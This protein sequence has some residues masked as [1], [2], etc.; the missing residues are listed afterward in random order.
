[1]EKKSSVIQKLLWAL[2]VICIPSCTQDTPIPNASPKSTHRTSVVAVDANTWVE[3]DR[4][5]IGS[6]TDGQCYEVWDVYYNLYTGEIVDEVYIDTYCDTVLDNGGYGG[7]GS[8]GGGGGGGDGSCRGCPNDDDL[9]DPFSDFEPTFIFPFAGN[10]PIQEYPNRCAGVQGLWNLSLNNN[11][12]ET[13]GVITADGKF[14]T[15]AVVGATGGSWGGL[16]YQPDVSASVYYSWPD[17]LGP[18]TQN[19]AGMRHV[20]NYYLI[21]I[22]ATVH[23]HS[24]CLVD[25]TDGITNITQISGGDLSIAKAYR[26][27]Q[28]YIVGCDAIGTYAYNSTVPILVERGRLENTC[29]NLN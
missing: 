27:I 15:V 5:A 11:N 8:G 9:A 26:T 24:P 23:T 7:G 12:Q 1:M 14:L 4:R 28:H 21:P 29:V 2:F 17:N 10:K 18:P 19:Y 3:R 13:V 25:G 20:A 6:L 16:Y 22:Q